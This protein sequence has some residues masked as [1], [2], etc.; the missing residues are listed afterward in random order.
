MGTGS[1]YHHFRT[2]DDL[3]RA[4]AEAEVARCT[5]EAEQEC[6][7]VSW[8]EGHREQIA[9]RAKLTLSNFR[10]FDKLLLLVQAEGDRLPDIRRAVSTALYGPGALAWVEDPSRLIAIAALAGHR[11]LER[12]DDK[13]LPSVSDDEF[14]EVLVSVM[15]RSRLPGTE[16]AHVFDNG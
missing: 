8:P 14:I 6:A 15:S 1:L 12:V 2:K 3:L 16:S 13:S 4:A 11:L 10:R 7:E 5:A 9:L